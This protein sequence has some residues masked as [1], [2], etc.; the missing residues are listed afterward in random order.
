[1][2][3]PY[4][5]GVNKNVQPKPYI[6]NISLVKGVPF[7]GFYVG[8]KYY[9]KIYLLNPHHMRR[10]SQI[11]QSGGIM[12]T[13]FQ[14]HEAHI[15]YIL[16]FMIDYNL[17]GCNFVDCE[18]IRFRQGV[19]DVDEIPEKHIW[20]NE[21]IP[22]QLMLP[23]GEFPRQSYSALEVDIGTHNILNRRK[24]CERNLHSSFIERLNPLPLDKKLL[25]SLAELWKDEN[26]RRGSTD[27]LNMENFVASSGSREP[28]T[29]WM[30]EEDKRTKILAMIKAERRMSDGSKPH[31]GDFVRHEPLENFVQT[32]LESVKDFFPDGNREM[33]PEDEDDGDGVDVDD[34]IIGDLNQ[35]DFVGEGDDAELADIDK[36]VLDPLVDEEERDED[37]E[38]TTGPRSKRDKGK[39][40]ANGP[41]DEPMSDAP[42]GDRNLDF[43]GQ[44]AVYSSTA[45]SRK[46]IYKVGS[47]GG[48]ANDTFRVP[49]VFVKENS[50]TETIE[51]KRNKQSNDKLEDSNYE[52][53]RDRIQLKRK[54]FPDIPISE[55]PLSKSRKIE[56]TDTGKALGPSKES[57]LLSKPS[58]SSLGK[59]KAREDQE[60]YHLQ[61]PR[62]VE[63][64]SFVVDS[65]QVPA[66]FP[67]TSSPGTWEF[68][69]LKT[70]TL[71][72]SQEISQGARR[73]SRNTPTDAGGGDISMLDESVSQ[74]SVVSSALYPATT[75]YSEYL[76][77]SLPQECH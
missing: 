31:F 41:V 28:S 49:P 3:K 16:Q 17:Y 59:M 9:A 21:S 69:V 53:P 42:L 50:E 52:I 38:S 30:H 56:S 68:P 51:I 48:H 33:T 37:Q 19:P 45:T 76:R 44:E 15:Q 34:D 46:D 60:N 43:G 25:H 13:I 62:A 27:Q 14:P 72:L 73:K 66:G 1:M 35:E 74:L 5:D 57:S 36:E 67:P 40:R 7:Y 58:A 26:R 20:H 55:R 4:S 64:M 77:S 70:E 23:E 61:P 32:A 47:E 11:L 39:G 29:D 65:V 63:Q 54:G 24:I 12:G 8:W 6:A 22:Q 18:N 2:N 71:R 75:Q 10:L